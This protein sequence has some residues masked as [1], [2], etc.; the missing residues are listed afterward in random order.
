MLLALNR[1]RVAATRGGIDDL[2][3]PPGQQ[4]SAKSY[5]LGDRCRML[6][7]SAGLLRTQPCLTLGG[8][9]STQ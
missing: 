1:Q 4:P 2:A 3:Q 7:G 5:R 9:G 6:S 8:G